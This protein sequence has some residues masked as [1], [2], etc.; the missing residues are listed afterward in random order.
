MKQDTE[1]ISAG[2]TE[3]GKQHF[4][5]V[6]NDYENILFNKSIALGDR[7][8]SL[9]SRREVT[10]DHVR[11]AAYS[12]ACS[13]GKTDQGKFGLFCHVG[14][15]VSTLTAGIGGGNIKETWGIVLLIASAVAWMLLFA[16]RTQKKG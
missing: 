2:F 15:Y 14:E 4:S 16:Y 3:S 10:H 7:D 12:I 11:S 8:K 6:T 5:K 13:Y 1:F 9:D